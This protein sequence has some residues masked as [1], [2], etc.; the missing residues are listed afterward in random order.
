MYRHCPEGRV[1]RTFGVGERKGGMEYSLS[2]PPASCTTPPA[3]SDVEFSTII[4]GPEAVS[5]CKVIM[6][7]I[8]PQWRTDIHTHLI[9]VYAGY[10]LP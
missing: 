2:A 8:N 5:S 4:I 3:A 9:H 10:G 1:A 6:L 7:S